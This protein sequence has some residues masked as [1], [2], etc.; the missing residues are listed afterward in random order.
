[1]MCSSGRSW[2][3]GPCQLPPAQMTAYPL[4]GGPGECV[5]DGVE[6]PPGELAIGLVHAAIRC[7]RVHLLHV[8]RG[9]FGADLHLPFRE[10]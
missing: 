3:C 7:H 5:I 1:M 6:A 4:L 9:S 2:V 10:A 8:L